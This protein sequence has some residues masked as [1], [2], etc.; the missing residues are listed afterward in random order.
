[1]N[2]QEP[3]HAAELELQLVVLALRLL[4]AHGMVTAH[5][6]G[7]LVRYRLTDG[8]ARRV[9]EIVSAVAVAPGAL[10]AHGA[11]DGDAS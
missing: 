4:R 10:H 3:L 5:R 9:L 2:G 1:M 7:R 11:D 8:L 6:E